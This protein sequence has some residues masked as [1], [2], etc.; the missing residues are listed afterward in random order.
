ML[1]NI[2]MQEL[3]EAVF[4]IEPKHEKEIV[5][6]IKS[7]KSLYSKW[8]FELRCA[9]LKIVFLIVCNLGGDTAGVA[10]P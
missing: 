3:R 6:L 9:T 1:T 7:Y 8:D 5:S 2:Y 10:N 4:N